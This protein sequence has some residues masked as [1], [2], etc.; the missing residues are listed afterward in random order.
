M[1]YERA[2]DMADRVARVMK[3]ASRGTLLHGPVLDWHLEALASMPTGS[4]ASDMQG[5]GLSKGRSIPEIAGL[6]TWEAFS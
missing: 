1:L 2:R 5:A 6:T 3:Q 4:S